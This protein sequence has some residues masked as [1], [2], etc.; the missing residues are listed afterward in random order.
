MNNSSNINR[1]W[2]L[3]NRPLGEPDN[4]TFALV[5]NDIPHIGSNQML[6]RHVF[7][8]LDPYMRGRLNEGKSY[9]PPVA[10]GEVMVGGTVSQVV[11]SNVAGFVAGDWVLHMGAGKITPCR[12]EAA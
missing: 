10:L 3:A 1:A 12:M 8:S 5:E 7:L 6:L 11:S 9:A 2:T 4:D